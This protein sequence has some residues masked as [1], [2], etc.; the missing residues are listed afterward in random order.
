VQYAQDHPFF[1]NVCLRQKKAHKRTFRLGIPLGNA[2]SKITLAPSAEWG[3]DLLKKGKNREKP[4]PV[5]FFSLQSIIIEF[6]GKF[7]SKKV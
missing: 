5:L 7:S 1:S 4:F 6:F 3:F 2:R